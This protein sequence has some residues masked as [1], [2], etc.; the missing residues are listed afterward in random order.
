MNQKHKGERTFSPAQRLNL[1]ISLYTYDAI[2]GSSVKVK[3]HKATQVL[4][5]IKT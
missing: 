1:L 4:P 5:S 2:E 3:T